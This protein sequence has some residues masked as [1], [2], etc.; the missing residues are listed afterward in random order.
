MRLLISG[1][2][3]FI[4]K[5]LVRRLVGNGHIIFSVVRPSTD[6]DFLKKEKIKF[7]VFD[8]DADKLI[9]FMKKEKFDGVIHLASLFLAQHSSENI[10]EL[11]DSNVI[12]P[13]ILL[14][15]SVKSD[16]P[17]FINTGTFWQHYDNK[18][19]S[20][21]NLYAATKQAFADISRY[22]IEISGINFVTIELSDTFGPVD[23]RPKIFNLL[24][25]IS[26]TGEALDMSPGNQILDINYIDNVID[27]YVRMV[28]LL[29]SDKNKKF[30]G[31]SFAMN[32]DER[33]TLKE[34]V[35]IFEKTTKNR[36]NINWGAKGYRPRE[37][38][39]PWRKGEKI[40]GWKQKISIQEG[41]NKTFNSKKY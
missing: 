29:Q 17:W 15:A 38:M 5:H 19:Y 11:L 36:L 13:T 7:H 39:I 30:K 41:I 40:P 25:K 27:G 24:M 23:T 21:V 33:M 16:I 2:T 8:G 22:F 12:F 31:R 26:K 1:A 34:L 18:K 4:G 37:V 10:K 3:G 32:S 14:E 20:P 28:D 6:F 35:G 9:S